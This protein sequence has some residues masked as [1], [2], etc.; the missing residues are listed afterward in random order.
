MHPAHTLSPRLAART[1]AVCA[2]LCAALL[3]GCASPS[4]T[5][6]APGASASTQT[7]AAAPAPAR[8]ATGRQIIAYF[9]GDQAPN[10]GAR[11]AAPAQGGY[12]RVLIDHFKTRA[13]APR[14][15]IQDFYQDSR[16]P[17]TTPFVVTDESDL[18]R[19]DPKTMEGRM[20]WLSP[21]GHKQTDAEFR[22]GQVVGPYTHYGDN[23]RVVCRQ[24]FNSAG[25]HGL[26]EMF[27]TANGKLLAKV[28]YRNGDPQ[29]ST[30]R[31]FDTNG[32]R[33]RGDAAIDR[34]N[35]LLEQLC[36]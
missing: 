21:E 29:V 13:G 16:T 12:Y 7:T 1:T 6:S 36:P 9:Q 27:N 34:Y 25:L 3:A 33:V 4:T 15:R 26:T 24:R 28:N 8:D 35:E 23:G 22:A 5:S 11:V 14:W 10:A 19:W 17:Q 2:A 31:V 20:S 30:L 18:G 32:R